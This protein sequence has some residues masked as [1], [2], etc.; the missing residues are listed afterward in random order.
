MTATQRLDEDSARLAELGYTSEFSR[1]MSLRANFAP[2]FTYLS[3]VVGVYA[4]FAFALAEAGPPVIWSLVIVGLGQLLVALVFG[5]IVSQYGVADGLN[6]AWPRTPDVA[7]YDNWIVVP[8][9]SWCWREGC[10]TCWP[11]GRGR[12]AR[13]RRETR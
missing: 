10:S 8:P 3:P 5:E 6:L 13:P 9:P 12:R 2:G 7:W 1:E 4:L 11:P